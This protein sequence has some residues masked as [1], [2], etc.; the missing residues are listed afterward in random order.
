MLTVELKK[1][2]VDVMHVDLSPVDVQTALLVSVI[3]FILCLWPT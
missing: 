3:F 1:C 2:V